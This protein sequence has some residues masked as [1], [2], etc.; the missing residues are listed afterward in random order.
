ME[1]NTK[2]KVQIICIA[3]PQ[4][5]TVEIVKEGDEYKVS[6]NKCKRGKEYAIN[7]LTNPTRTLTTTVKTSFPD[8]PRLPVK[9][10]K[11]IPLGDVFECMSEINAIVVDKR[12]KP[13]DVVSESLLG[14]DVKLLATADMT[15][16]VS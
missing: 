9:T 13:G 2:E 3:C 16:F 5:C 1:Q 10:D 11:E 7:E 15:V 14:T 12:L 6:G 4:G 8:F